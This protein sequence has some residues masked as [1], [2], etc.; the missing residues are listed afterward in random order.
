MTNK[1]RLLC[2]LSKG[3]PDRLPVTIHQ[4]QPYHLKK[5]MNGMSDIEAFR[6]CGLDA[7]I[8]AARHIDGSWDHPDWRVSCKTS[9]NG[10]YTVYDYTVETP[11]G[12]LAYQQQAN[13]TTVFTTE[14]MVKKDEDIQI[15]KKHLHYPKLDK[16]AMQKIYD[17]IGDMGILRTYI[18]GWQPG[19]WQD[20]T[21]FAGTE[22]MILAAF[23]KPDWV[24]EFLGILLEKKLEFIEDSLRGCCLDLVENGGGASSNTV[25][26]PS[27]HEEF[28]LPYDKKLHDALHQVGLKS[29]YHTCGGMTKILNLILA[30]GCDASETLSPPTIGGDIA[31]PKPVYDALH[32]KVCLIGGLDQFVTL[33]DGTPADIQKEVS[34]L[35]E[36]F[37]KG[38]GYILS[39]SDHFFCT[40]VENLK[41]MANAARTC[42]Y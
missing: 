42:I 26:S 41:A 29:T 31:D 21:M 20:A 38:G 37:G 30:N 6:H 2:A 27:M 39:A 16:N 8:T 40:P 3:V 10:D 13:E 34:R 12:R 32:G 19:C 7:S 36:G 11:D 22:E 18:H 17:E 25:I 14:H 28:C 9:Q 4:W 24:H 1:E 35:F 5:Y 33:T 15:I 23:D